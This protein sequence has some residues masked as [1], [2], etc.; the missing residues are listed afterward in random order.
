MS[1]FSEV[2]IQEST[3]V[4]EKRKLNKI[5]IE[6][7][8]IEIGLF[9]VLRFVLMHASYSKEPVDVR[10]F[11]QIFVTS[12][13]I[14]GE[15]LLVPRPTPKQEGHPLSATA[16]SICSQLPSVPRGRLLHSQPEDAPCRGDIC[17]WFCM[18]V[19]LGL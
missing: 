11:L 17:L 1:T 13:F 9:F 2:H 4:I 16:Y 3:L 18:G 6:F 15:E 5:F 19:K 10:G 12:L 8:C 7:R 14:Y